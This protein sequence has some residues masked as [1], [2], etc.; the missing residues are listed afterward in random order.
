M[1]KNPVPESPDDI[2]IA[3]AIGLYDNV[4]KPVE[5]AESAEEVDQ[6][7]RENPHAGQ[8]GDVYGDRRKEELS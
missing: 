3:R 6:I 7:L 4:V 8:I 2:L 1:G 5:N